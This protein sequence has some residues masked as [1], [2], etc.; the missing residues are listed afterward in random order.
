MHN[1]LLGMMNIYYREELGK[2]IREVIELDVDKE[3]IGWGLYL[4]VK[5]WLDISKPLIRD[6]LLNF[7]GSQS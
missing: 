5:V 7:A 2:S 4:R 1:V 6:K 3:G